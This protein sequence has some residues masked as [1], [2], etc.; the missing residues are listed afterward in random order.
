MRPRIGVT[1]DYCCRLPAFKE[2]YTDLKRMIIVDVGEIAMTRN[3]Q[4]NSYWFSLKNKPDAILFYEAA[5]IPVK[6]YGKEFD[7]TYAKYFYDEE[8]QKQFLEEYSYNLYA[9][10]EVI[11]KTDIENINLMQTHLGD[12]VLIDRIHNARKTLNTF[13]FLAKSGLFVKSVEF[14]SS[15]ELSAD[16]ICEQLRLDWL[17]DPYTNKD[18][19]IDPSNSK[20]ASEHLLDW[21]YK[22]ENQ[23]VDK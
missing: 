14:I 19:C 15:A 10:A 21:F 16:E 18:Q 1:L 8:D 9:K 5:E 7:I 11:N 12:V 13:N 22:I 2:A 20:Q 4:P 17:W 3:L 23:I 6:D